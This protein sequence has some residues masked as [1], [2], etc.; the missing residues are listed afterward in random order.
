VPT[1]QAR[2]YLSRRKI[3]KIKEKRAGLESSQTCDL[4]DA[5]GEMVIAGPGI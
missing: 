5:Y 1:G 3:G 2:W 4:P